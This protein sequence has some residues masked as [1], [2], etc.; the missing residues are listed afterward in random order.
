MSSSINGLNESEGS[1]PL[2]TASIIGSSEQLYMTHD[3]RYLDVLQQYEV[4]TENKR[5]FDLEE[6]QWGVLSGSCVDGT[7]WSAEEKELFFQAVARNGKRDLDL[8]AYSIPSKSAVQI[9]RYINALENELHWLRNHVDASVRSQCLLKYEDIPIAMEM[10]QNWI[11]WEEKIAERLLEGS[12]ISGAETSPY[13]AQSVKNKTS[14]EDL[15]DTNE[16]RKISERFYHFD[17]QAPF[18]SNPL[19]AGATEFLLQIIKSKLKELIGTS[20]FLAESRFR[21]LEANNAFHRKPI[22]KNRDV[23]LSGKFLRFHRFNIPGFWKYLPTRQKMNVY[24]RNKRLKFQ[25]YIH[26][27]ESD[28]RQSKMKLGRVRAR[29]TKNNENTMFFD[30]KEHS[31]DESDGNLGEHDVK[32]KVDSVSADETSINGFKKSVNQ[33]EYPDNAQMFMDESVAEESLVEIDDSVEAYDMIQSKNY[34]SFVW[35]YVL[36]LTDEI[37]TEDALF[38]TIPLSNLLAQK[39]MKDKLKGSDVF[40]TLKITSKSLH[41]IDEHSDS[42]DEV[43]P[44]CYY[45]KD[46]VVSHAPDAAEDVS[47]L[48]SGYV[49]LISYDLSNLPNSTEDPERKLAK[50]VSSWELSLPL[51]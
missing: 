22:I 43:Q 14:N 9:E 1:T 13:N 34:E 8:I 5:D 17:R 24:K 16:M 32:R 35:K 10:S 50:P 7:Y 18:P 31:T 25:N 46:P 39:R 15:F 44:I 21:K 41:N 11:D 45:Y 37:S 2:S 3:E 48:E 49:G 27:M 19:S 40:T 29:K 23:V 51:K 26:I 36:H 12:N 20:I 28:E 33:V 42:D 38:E 30:S 6:E 47:E 4:E